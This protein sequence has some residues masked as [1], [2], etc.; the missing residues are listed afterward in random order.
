MSVC[1]D[2]LPEIPFNPIRNP[3]DGDQVG[4]IDKW[5]GKINEFLFTVTYF[6]HHLTNRF[7]VVDC[8]VQ[9][10][11]YEPFMWSVIKNFDSA[12]TIFL[13]NIIWIKN[14]IEK[15]NFSVY[16]KDHNGILRNVYSS[17]DKIEI[18][19]LKIYLEK[20]N[21][22]K[23]YFIYKPEEWDKNWCIINKVT[24]ECIYDPE[25]G[26]EHC[27]ETALLARS[28]KNVETIVKPKGNNAFY[29]KWVLCR[30]DDN[31]N[32]FTVEEY[33]S[34][35]E[36]EY[37]KSEFERKRHKQTYWIEEMSSYGEKIIL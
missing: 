27:Q 14:E 29:P 16:T 28:F 3:D 9:Q 5:Y 35:L 23:I 10:Q 4:P 19:E 18:S 11:E 7:A 34:K 20:R 26:R 30:Q 25:H 6:H 22:A 13:E 15:P 8:M 32:I 17:I 21:S 12:P 36:A 37:A 31:G 24:G 1:A 2:P 33:W